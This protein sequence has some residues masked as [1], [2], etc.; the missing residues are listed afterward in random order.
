M[1]PNEII[2]FKGKR[3]KFFHFD[4]P[5]INGDKKTDRK[6]ACDFCDLKPEDCKGIECIYP[7]GTLYL[8]EI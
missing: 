8:K 3:Y 7:D 1:Q 4:A 2:T 6:Q 5:K